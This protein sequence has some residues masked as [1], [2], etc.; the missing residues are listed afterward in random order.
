MGAGEKISEELIEEVLLL[1]FPK[2]VNLDKVNSILRYNLAYLERL[3]P[4]S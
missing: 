3:N 1:V 4:N 2:K